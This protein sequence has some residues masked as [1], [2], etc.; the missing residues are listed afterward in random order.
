MIGKLRFVALALA[1]AALVSSVAQA[2]SDLRSGDAGFAQAYLQQLGLTH[3]QATAWTTGVCSY[4]VK[5]SSCELTPAEANTASVALGRALLGNS[6]LTSAQV[7]AWVQGVCSYKD[8]PAS[9]D[10]TPAEASFASKRLAESLGDGTVRGVVP[11]SRPGFDWGDAL[12]GAA[13]AAGIFLLG[14]AGAL[15]MRRRRELAHG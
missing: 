5:P 6:T 9:C 12:I 13:V 8:K 11:V 4:R 2:K 1:A 15:A 14:A 10:L 3:R 7:D